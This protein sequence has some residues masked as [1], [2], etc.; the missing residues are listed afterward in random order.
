MIHFEN[1]EI[2]Q[3]LADPQFRDW[4]EK[5]TRALEAYWQEWINQNADKKDKLLLARE[6]L[7]QLQAESLP[8]DEEKEKENIGKILQIVAPRKRVFPYTRLAAACVLIGLC[9]FLVTHFSNRSLTPKPTAVSNDQHETIFS[10]S[11]QQ[12]QIV[13]L[14]DG[15]TVL[16][17]PNSQLTVLFSDSMRAVFLTGEAYFE[18]AKNP[19]LPFEV[20]T[21]HITTRVIGTSFRVRD[22]AKE[23]PMVR[24]NTGK[25]TVTLNP[26]TEP[27]LV[28]AQPQEPIILSPQEMVMVENS[29][30]TILSP[31]VH[32]SPVELIPAEMFEHV[33]KRTP[34]EEVFE[35]LEHIYK[36]KI[37]YDRDKLSDCSL[38]AKLGDEPLV[39]KLRMICLGLNL[40]F[41][42]KD[43][44]FYIITGEG[45]H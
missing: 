25:V 19:D 8:L 21:R 16:L 1:E 31:D 6:I 32:K 28:G 45:C 12:E 38:T 20:K 18:I 22:N 10:N 29:M 26:D 33:Y 39:E 42:Q 27:A 15:S 41:E 13:T 23:T 37:V 4:V 43:A 36:V 40:N 30:L 35:T 24:V 14:D 34:V 17:H 9:A 7:L 3:F 11:G 2:E 44:D 5:P